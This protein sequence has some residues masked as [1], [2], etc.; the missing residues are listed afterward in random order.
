MEQKLITI[1][2]GSGF[3][4]SYIVTELAKTGAI[5]QVVSRNPD[6]GL[7]LKPA[8]PIGQIV[9]TKGNIR[10]EQSV[11]E[12][13]KGSHIVINTVGVLHETGKQR[14]PALHAQGPELLAKAA[15]EAG[16]ERFIHFS[17]LGIDKHTKSRY[18]RSKSTGEKAVL[19]AFP[20]ATILRPSIVFGAEDRFFNKFAAMG[21][22]SPVLPLIGGGKTLFQPIY[23]GDIARATRMILDRPY[24]HTQIFELGG[25]RI[26]SFKQLMQ[27]IL[28]VIH[29]RR[30][31]LPL[32]FALA[33]L[34]GSV[35]EFMPSSPLTR[36]QVRLLKQDNIVNPAK[37]G[38]LTLDDLGLE[39]NS[40]EM[41]LPSY[42]L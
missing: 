5:I 14:F 32:P 28:A 41:I 4:G 35:L 23:V 21:R 40:L 42:L 22:L 20:T 25:P 16:A 27:L 33:T 13:V 7:F 6:A 31:L 17:A 8:G 11:R 24:T 3:I 39:A 37:G 12:A 38:I 18:A 26:Y 15:K 34:M 30:L 36:D 29:K 2:G 19:A 9:L 10:N 1:F